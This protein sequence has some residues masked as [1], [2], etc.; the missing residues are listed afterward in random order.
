M[1]RQEQGISPSEKTEGKDSGFRVF[2]LEG[3]PQR[4]VFIF[5]GQA[6]PGMGSELKPTRATEKI[7]KNARK[8]LGYDIRDFSFDKREGILRPGISEIAA[9][10]YNHVCFTLAS[11]SRELP[12]PQALAGQG[13]GFY[14]ALVASGAISFEQG[15][16]F[17]IAEAEG[18]QKIYDLCKGRLVAKTLEAGG[19][20]RKPKELSEIINELEKKGITI[21]AI[22]PEGQIEIYSFREIFEQN[23]TY[24]ENLKRRGIMVSARRAETPFHLHMASSS[25]TLL[26]ELGKAKIKDAKIPVVA[27][28]TGEPIQKEGEI[29]QE[30]ASQSINTIRWD[31]VIETIEARGNLDSL[32]LGSGGFL[33]KARKNKKA[34][35][36]IIVV[37]AGVAS[38]LAYGIH[39]LKTKK[40]K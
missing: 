20:W 15:L 28:T 34:T 24:F 5:S 8:L 3:K 32:E 23:Q 19:E 37:S 16:R 35:V 13:I 40:S 4:F 39:R 36:A 1:A 11:E 17:A 21:E 9:L 31:K 25:L 6:F 10:V 27:P 26:E 22:G 12:T 29:R 33:S 2:C 7:Y 30:I 18:A 38:A 14:N